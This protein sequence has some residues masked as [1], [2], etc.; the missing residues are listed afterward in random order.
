MAAT[1]LTPKVLPALPD[2]VK[3]LVSGGRAVVI[4]GN[5]L[6]PT[7]QAFTASLRMAGITG[8]VTDDDVALSRRLMLGLCLGLGGE[9]A[10]VEVTGLSLPGPARPVGLRH[11]RATEVD[12]PALVFFHGG[13]YT[14]GDLDAYDALCRLFCRNAGIHVFSVDYRLA[15]EHPAPAAVDDCLAAFRWVTAHADEFGVRPDRVAI[16]GDS[17]GGGLTAAV[18][19]LSRGDGPA[20]ALQLLIYP[21]TDIRTPTRSRTLFASGL[22]LC[23]HDIAWCG[24]RYLDGSGVAADD[25][26]VSP[27]RSDDLSGLPPALVVTAGF[28]PL[29]DEG[30]A[31]AAALAAAGVPVDLREMGSMTHGFMNFNGLG[32]G[33]AACIAEVTSALRAHL[34]RG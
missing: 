30:N 4:D 21:W 19:Q 1:R 31:Y 2:A 11:Y 12:A 3:R 20:P 32:G 17:A 24:D 25:P 13:G 7:L 15:P 9:R 5:T 16:G 6:D 27:G 28:D 34:R 29:R 8:L 26:R 14:F 33:A 23:D 10:P 22:V 18:A